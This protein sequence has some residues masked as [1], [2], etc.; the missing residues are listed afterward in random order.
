MKM[1]KESNSNPKDKFS[2]IG[3]DPYVCRPPEGFKS[4][5]AYAK[6][7]IQINK[8]FSKKKK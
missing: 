6:K 4:W 8:K 1:L 5:T 2:Y 3:I 7:E